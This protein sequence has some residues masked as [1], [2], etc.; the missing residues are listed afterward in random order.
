M[1]RSRHTGSPVPLFINPTDPQRTSSEGD[2]VSWNDRH[3]QILKLW[4]EESVCWQ[5]MHEMSHRKYSFRNMQLTLP[6]IV[7]S[8]VTGTA[9][10]AMS[11]L[12]PEWQVRLPV[13][14]GSVNILSGMI[15]TIAQYLRIQE[16][17]EGHRVAALSYGKLVRNVTSELSLVR[18]ERS[19]S[20]LPL[21][22]L[23][24]NEMD[25]LEEQSPEIDKDIINLF[26]EKFGQD[27]LD[28][29]IARPSNMSI[30]P[31]E[32]CSS[33][34]DDLTRRREASIYS[35]GRK[36][37]LS[38]QAS[39]LPNTKRVS[40]ISKFNRKRSEM[41]DDSISSSAEEKADCAV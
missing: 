14:I 24:R 2:E 35:G 13:I 28:A 10:F 6:V 29:E 15:T 17:N 30:R 39:M 36:R 21:V 16:R 3:E 23:C 37:A 19:S 22:R 1:N 7:M 5:R 26:D 33:D 18:E 8:T 9:N 38:P 31:I 32:I 25:R 12:S 20:G 34:N 4:A 40:L 11:S 27:V 41:S